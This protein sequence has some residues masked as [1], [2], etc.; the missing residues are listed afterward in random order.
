MSKL[1]QIVSCQGLPE[2]TK[3]L[4]VQEK[5]LENLVPDRV[6]QVVTVT[7]EVH[8]EADTDPAA[9]LVMDKVRGLVRDR[10]RAAHWD[11][12]VRGKRVMDLAE[13]RG[14]EGARA[15]LDVDR[16]PGDEGL[17]PGT[18]EARAVVVPFRDTRDSV[19]VVGVL[20]RMNP[21]E[22]DWVRELLPWEDHQ[23]PVEGP[24]SSQMTTSNTNSKNEAFQKSFLEEDLS[25]Y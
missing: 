16:V 15:G 17:G 21:E 10:D 18:G 4:P 23:R 13:N 9:E 14:R 6:G 1:E 24:R 19:R 20:E 7:E 12:V 8:R 22:V 2:R 25:Q 5:T 3:N 11:L